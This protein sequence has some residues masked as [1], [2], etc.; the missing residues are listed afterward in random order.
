VLTVLPTFVLTVPRAPK[1]L[2]KDIDKC[3]R[4]F[5]WAH[6]EELSGGKCKVN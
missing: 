3:R 5:L 2:L 4:R 1:K 6:D